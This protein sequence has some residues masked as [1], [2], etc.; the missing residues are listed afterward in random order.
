MRSLIP[1]RSRAPRR[2][3]TIAGVSPLR[4]IPSSSCTASHLT[5]S[6]LPCRLRA[7]ISCR[8][9]RPAD[10][11]PGFRSEFVV[12]DHP[13]HSF[14]VDFFLF[15]FYSIF[16]VG[17][18]TDGPLN[19]VIYI[20]HMSYIL[21]CTI[22]FLPLKLYTLGTP[23]FLP[24]ALSLFCLSRRRL[25]SFPSSS[26]IALSCA[27]S[28]PLLYVRVLLFLRDRHSSR[29]LCLCFPHHPPTVVY[30]TVWTLICRPLSF[31]FCQYQYRYPYGTV[32]V[33]VY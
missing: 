17:L 13:Q 12:F 33:S 19:A 3:C 23:D 10:R 30:R 1:L 32:S 18:S 20:Y 4:A 21:Y 11:V 6:Q 26:R 22:S 7:I 25:A 16:P 8:S 31:C 14:Q 27:P 5:S 15:V 24:F 9:P 2:P 28:F 29:E